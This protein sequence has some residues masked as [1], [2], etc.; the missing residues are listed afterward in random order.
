M[1]QQVFE[2]LT[3]LVETF[4]IALFYTM[5]LGSKHT[6]YRK[7]IYFIIAW[8]VGFVEICIVNMVTVFETFAAYIPILIYF[9]YGLLCLKGGV[10]LKLWMAVITH[11]IVVM[12]AVVTN[13]AVCWTIGYDPKLVITVFD[14]IRIFCVVLSKVVL[15]LCYFIILRNRYK[16]P[17]RNYLWYML[18]IIPLF[19]V[20]SISVLMKIALAY[21]DCLGYVLTGMLCIVAANVLIYYFYT[22]IS[23]DYENKL[24]VSLLEQQNE[25]ALNNIK[26]SEAFVSKMRTV[27]HDI[28]NQFYTIL[29]YME[30]NRFED[31]KSYIKDLTEDYMPTFK[32]FVTTNNIA[33]DAV[34]NS[35]LTVCEQKRIYLE[36]KVMQNS[37]DKFDYTDTGILFG[38]LLDNA[39]EA[40]SLSD[41]KKMSLE[42]EKR[43]EYL[44]VLVRNSING[45]VLET[46]KNLETTKSDKDI[47]GIGIKS[48]KSVVKKYDGMIDF[49]EENGEFCCHIMLNI[50]E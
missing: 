24:K 20:I 48:I 25:N 14:N 1:T 34:I 11:I 8:L 30:S 29:G 44:S 45:S 23:R 38:N 28:K 21:N 6:D 27:R 46:N 26:S 5:Y 42:V 39:I 16:Y 31:A 37:V 2:T 47:H 12:V 49:F 19:S 50:E 17:I 41:E 15:C 10:L 43:G 33:F 32:S 36:I 22:V 7:Y 18:I 40:A 35:K 9:I 13:V 3:N 4:I